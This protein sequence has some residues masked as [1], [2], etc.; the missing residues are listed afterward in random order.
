MVV[1][2]S[3]VLFH[4]NN[5]VKNKFLFFYGGPYLQTQQTILETQHNNFETQHNIFETQHK[6]IETQHKVIE[7]QHK[8]I[9]TQHKIIETQHKI[10]GTQH[11]IIETQHKIIKT[12][13]DITGTQK[14]RQ[15]R[16]DWCAAIQRTNQFLL[17]RWYIMR[18]T[19][20][21]HFSW[22]VCFGEMFCAI[23]WPRNGATLVTNQC[24]LLLHTIYATGKVGF[25]ASHQP[26]VKY[27]LG[28]KPNI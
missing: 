10:I 5:T 6:I 21:R 11:K 1:V 18:L 4:R 22:P 20:S 28:T 24:H 2:F 14:A 9:G 16:E 13:H 26:H 25:C 8:I 27:S 7:T 23:V 12:Q 15:L 17:N 19:N 3:L